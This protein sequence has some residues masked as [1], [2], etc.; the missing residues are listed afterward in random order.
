MQVW[1]ILP[2]LGGKKRFVA[3]FDIKTIV[4]LNLRKAI[5]A[6]KH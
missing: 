4:V 3:D 6:L 5:C 2:H 1:N